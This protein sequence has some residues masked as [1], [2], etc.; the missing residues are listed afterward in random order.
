[1]DRHVTLLT[2]FALVY[3][4]AN[5]LQLW[6]LEMVCINKSYIIYFEISVV[7]I[8]HGFSF[9]GGVKVMENQCWKRGRTLF[10]VSVDPYPE[11]LCTIDQ[12][13]TYL[14]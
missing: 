8:G 9:F 6:S 14:L 13:S 7:P 1:M 5:F 4:L 10:S 2:Q 3:L 11:R 12:N